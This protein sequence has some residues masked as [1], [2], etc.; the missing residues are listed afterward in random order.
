MPFSR[1]GTLDTQDAWDV[2]MFMDAHERPQDPRYTGNVDETR[3]RYHDTPMSL[4][5]I[6]I[7]GHVLG[8]PGRGR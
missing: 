1:G 3:K 4:Y 7:N 8:E 5:G 2:A 6:E